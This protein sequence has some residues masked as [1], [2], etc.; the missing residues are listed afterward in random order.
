M[1]R[2]WSSLSSSSKSG[3]QQSQVQCA[4]V[5]REPGAATLAK[6][7]EAQPIKLHCNTH[8]HDDD[9]HAHDNANANDDNDYNENLIHNTELQYLYS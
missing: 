8:N 7:S 5:A 3:L 9:E 1:I 4:G 6:S 2:L